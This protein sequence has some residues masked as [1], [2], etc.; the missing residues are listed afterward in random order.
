[1]DLTEALNEKLD[2]LLK[3]LNNLHGDVDVSENNL[4]R[5]RSEK[6]TQE[7]HDFIDS[8]KSK[9]EAKKQEI[10]D[11]RAQIQVVKNA[12]QKEFKKDYT[13]DFTDEETQLLQDAFNTPSSFYQNN[14]NETNK[15]LEAPKR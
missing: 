2:T 9:I 3:D 1:M 11:V 6:E 15:D 7:I 4:K 5:S 8:L 14:T 12:E 10:E 13:D